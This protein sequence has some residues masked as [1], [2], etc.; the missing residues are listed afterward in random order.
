[1][2]KELQEL[3]IWDLQKLKHE[4][5][6]YKTDSDLTKIHGIISNLPGNL[7]LHLCG[8]LQNY[9]GASLGNTSYVRDRDKEFS[10]KEFTKQS[11]LS[12]IDRTTD[13][14]NSTFS[15]LKESDLNNTY[16]ET[17]YW[18]GFSIAQVLIICSNHFN[19]HLGQI[20]YHRRSLDT[21]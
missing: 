7:C 17:P 18:K 8:N 5:T 16:P 19:Y 9:I 13:A 20:N 11:L 21:K 4:I 14:V 1:M 2:L 10:Q 15:K 3:F 6:S 12:E